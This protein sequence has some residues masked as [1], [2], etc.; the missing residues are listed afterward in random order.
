M[1]AAAHSDCCFFV[2]CTHILTYL[3]TTEFF[4]DTYQLV[5]FRPVVDMLTTETDRSKLM[6]L[7]YTI[8]FDHE[9]LVYF[10]GRNA[11]GAKFIGI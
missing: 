1:R 9:N 2:L 5:A 7:R 8:V 10:T 3:L 11:S 6:I 4:Y